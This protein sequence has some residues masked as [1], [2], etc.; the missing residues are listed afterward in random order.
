MHTPN[1]DLLASESLLFQR[2]YCQEAFCS[3][4]RNS[5]MSGR[6]TGTTLVWGFL[7]SFRESPLG[8]GGETWQSMP[9]YF[10]D[11]GY[12]TVGAGKT[13]HTG[14]PPNFDAPRSWTEPSV[15]N[16]QQNFA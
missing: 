4:S 13:Y 7:V 16:R 6:R 1:F 12:L 10:K 3:A 15:G 5:F 11:H 2:A 9:E 8:G 14:S